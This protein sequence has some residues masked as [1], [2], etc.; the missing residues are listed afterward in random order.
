[1]N[2][3]KFIIMISL[4][5]V[6]SIIINSSAFASAS[7]IEGTRSTSSPRNPMLFFKKMISKFDYKT[8]YD[9]WYL[10]NNETDTFKLFFM[11]D[12]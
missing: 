1:M 11:I 12:T 9:T 10:K 4:I 8:P 3:L 6:K 2:F 5:S 7:H